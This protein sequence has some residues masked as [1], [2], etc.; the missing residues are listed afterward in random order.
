MRQGE[1]QASGAAKLPRTS[2]A[3]TG[4][5]RALPRGWD[6]ESSHEVETGVGHE[7]AHH[8][9]QVEL[10]EQD[11]LDVDYRRWR[12]EK[13]AELDTAYRRWKRDP[14]QPFSSEFEAWRRRR[15]AAPA[16][17]PADAGAWPESGE[18]AADESLPQGL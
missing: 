2:N 17:K 1:R 10:S 12:N 14:S 16:G 9:Y 4:G 11:E 6:S 5:E 13:M 15:A 8:G 18:T 3:A 7:W